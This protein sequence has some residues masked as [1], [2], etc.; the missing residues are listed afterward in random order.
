MEI[1]NIFPTP[2]YRTNLGDILSEESLEHITKLKT[3]KLFDAVPNISSSDDVLSS[4]R[5]DALRV[6]IQKH[7]QIFGDILFGAGL[8]FY[9]SSSWV[10]KSDTLQF[11]ERHSHVNSIISG[12]FYVSPNP[13]SIIFYRESKST[14]HMFSNNDSN[15]YNKTIIPIQPNKNDLILFPSS[16]E[17][18]I[19][20]NTDNVSRFSVVVNSY[21]RGQ[22]MSKY[23]KLEIK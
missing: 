7:L 14:I 8:E 15:Y 13:S 5:L 1:L 10:T 17:H 19:S 21:I 9:I 23:A 11:G 4:D 6:A 3:E 2:V 16:L 18:S 22:M 12:S 20:K